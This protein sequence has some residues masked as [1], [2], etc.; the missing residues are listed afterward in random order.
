MLKTL[1][2][3]LAYE[4]TREW[5]LEPFWWRLTRHA[6]FR[7]L[8]IASFVGHVIAIA[9]LIRL[10]MARAYEPLPER[11]PRGELV[12]IAEVAPPP[13]R[14]PNLRSASEAIERTD[15][16][17]LRFDPATAND[18]HLTARAPKPT[19]A[20]GTPN[21][22]AGASQAGKLPSASEIERQAQSRRGTGDTDRPAAT[23]KQP[24][25]PEVSPVA[26]ARMPTPDSPAATSGIPTPPTSAPPT[27]SQ[28]KPATGAAP[29]NSPPAAAAGQ[30]G[31]DANQTTSLG[32]QAAEAQYLAYVRAKIRKA[33]ER[34]MPRQWI[35]GVLADK[36]SADFAVIVRRTGQIASA[37]LVRSSGYSQLDDIARQAIYIA[38]PFE[39]YPQ[40]AGDTITLTV[41]VHYAPG[42]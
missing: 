33:N 13:E 32:L 40:D 12:Q 21:A 3:Y 26:S 39:G 28:P 23:S 35:E 18:T 25:P 29:A 24:R 11:A 19:T 30:R 2:N 42:R 9:L 15:T 5:L 34:I 36:V 4:Q 37:R 22:P 27:P 6:R 10:D 41:T 20:R 17:N 31:G 1:D 16:A 8:L 7:K 38:N 14:P